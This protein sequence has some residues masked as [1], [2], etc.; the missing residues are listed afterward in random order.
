MG[1]SQAQKEARLGNLG[2][3]RVAGWK[4]LASRDVPSPALAAGGAGSVRASGAGHLSRASSCG[5]GPA[6]VLLKR[7][8]FPGRREGAR[9]RKPEWWG[10]ERT[11]RSLF[12]LETWYESLSPPGRGGSA[13][14]HSPCR[15]PAGLTC[16]KGEGA[17]GAP[18]LGTSAFLQCGVALSLLWTV[19]PELAGRRALH[20]PPDPACAPTGRYSITAATR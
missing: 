13:S 18:S 12:C 8:E 11:A 19:S 16:A 4:G 6:P 14:C 7:N 15:P 9:K 2:T 3:G 17:V 20:S 10:Q 5:S 1:S